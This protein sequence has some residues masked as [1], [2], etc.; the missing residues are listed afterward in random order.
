MVC[1]L[2]SPLFLLCFASLDSLLAGSDVWGLVQGRGWLESWAAHPRELSAP[3]CLRGEQEWAR[4]TPAG[5]LWE[6]QRNPE[7]HWGRL[8]YLGSR[9][10]G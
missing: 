7:S 5:G 2:F 6:Q 3:G 10:S 1:V 9:F 8:T 4:G